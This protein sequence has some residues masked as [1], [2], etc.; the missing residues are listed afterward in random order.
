MLVTRRKNRAIK[1][2]IGG[3]TG[4][5]IKS[6][7]AVHELLDFSPALRRVP[8]AQSQEIPSIAAAEGSFFPIRDSLASK[9]AKGLTSVQEALNLLSLEG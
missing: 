1:I 3:C 6:R 2:G 7:V 9:V 4:R 5:V 8:E